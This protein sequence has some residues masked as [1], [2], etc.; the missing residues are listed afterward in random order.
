MTE[1]MFPL[2]ARW[3]CLKRTSS[4][5]NNNSEWSDWQLVARLSR[6]VPPLNKQPIFKQVTAGQYCFRKFQ[7]LNNE[8]HPLGRLTHA[9]E[10]IHLFK[11]YQL[12]KFTHNTP[13]M[14]V[15]I[16]FSSFFLSFILIYSFIHF[17][18]YLGNVRF[19]SGTFWH[20]Q[21]HQNVIEMDY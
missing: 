14:S 19:I 15:P 2:S 11:H 7:K 4:S 5:S 18:L 6:H 1:R 17:F 3:C 16:F 20:F 9:D 10:L 13:D 21:L 12:T 8:Q